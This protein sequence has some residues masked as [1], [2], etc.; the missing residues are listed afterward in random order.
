MSGASPTSD[1]EQPP[2]HSTFRAATVTGME[3]K[4]LANIR[5]KIDKITS[6][7]PLSARLSV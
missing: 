4:N 6:I 1:A 3:K 7:D 5:D 2:S